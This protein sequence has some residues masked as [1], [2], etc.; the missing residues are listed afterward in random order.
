HAASYCEQTCPQGWEQGTKF[1]WA[2]TPREDESTILGSLVVFQRDF[3]LRSYSGSSVED[4]KGT[5]VGGGQTDIDAG[6]WE[7]GYWVSPSHR[8]QGYLTEALDAVIRWIF[9]E[10]P[11]QLAHQVKSLG[12]R[13]EV[14]NEA[15]RRVILPLG[16]LLGKTIHN[17]VFVEG[18]KPIDIWS[19]TLSRDG[20]VSARARTGP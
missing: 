16:F 6:L 18:R 19:A 14:G 17:F 15:S 7:V 20:F 1:T 4:G 5:P 2:I 8:G 3:V 12:W 13:A 11:P 9:F 10:A